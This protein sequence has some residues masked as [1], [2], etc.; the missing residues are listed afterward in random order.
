MYGVVHGPWESLDLTF[1]QGA[2]CRCPFAEK[3]SGPF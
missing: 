3:V 1:D 2:P